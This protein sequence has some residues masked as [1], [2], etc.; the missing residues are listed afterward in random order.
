[1]RLNGRFSDVAI[2]CFSISYLT[3]IQQKRPMKD[4]YKKNNCSNAI[5]PIP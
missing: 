2:V 1:M 3:N 4:K 5:I